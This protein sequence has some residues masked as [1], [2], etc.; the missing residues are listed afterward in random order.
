MRNNKCVPVCALHI[1]LT[2]EILFIVKVIKELGNNNFLLCSA[3]SPSHL[4]LLLCRDFLCV[5]SA[6]WQG[7][8][9]QVEAVHPG[10]GFWWECGAVL[11]LTGRE[12]PD[13]L[14]SVGHQ[15]HNTAPSPSL[16]SP[17]PFMVCVRTAVLRM[18][19]SLIL[20][21][22][23]LLHS[24]TP[25]S[26]NCDDIM[27][28]TSRLLLCNRREA[29]D[30][31]S[32]PEIENSS[33]SGWQM[34]RV[35]RMNN[36]WC[37]LALPCSCFFTHGRIS[38]AANSSIAIRTWEEMMS[39]PLSA[40]LHFLWVF[41]YVT[42]IIIIFNTAVWSLFLMQIMH[43]LHFCSFCDILFIFLSNVCI[44]P[45]IWEGFI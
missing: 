29:C 20:H 36:I 44:S 12:R 19:E 33:R 41:V 45:V 3:S 17:H 25:Y 11:L 7:P 21:T 18:R 10:G 14:K 39:S 43:H 15:T 6:G 26:W 37:K 16:L 30:S 40:L 5:C 31:C 1:R 2:N 23:H 4:I 24:L 22:G 35:S 27:Q 13:S 8:E 42:W 38:A 9:S 32:Q 28:E 34:P